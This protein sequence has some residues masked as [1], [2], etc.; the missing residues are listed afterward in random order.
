MKMKK[1]NA[2]QECEENAEYEFH[3]TLTCYDCLFE[4]IKNELIV[5]AIDEYILCNAQK[6]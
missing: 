1:C 2:H 4:H 6:L 5:D 3:N